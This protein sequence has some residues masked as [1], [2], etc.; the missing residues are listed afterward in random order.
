M[1]NSDD[2]FLRPDATRMRPRP[3]GGRRT[4]VEPPRTQVAQATVGDAGSLPASARALIG[5]GLNPLVRAATPL[6]LL[7]AQIRESLGS[8]DVGGLRRSALEEIH[9]FEATARASR[10]PNEVVLAA[11]YVLCAALDEA[12]LSTPWGNQS[13]WAQHPLLVAVHREAWGGEKFFDMLDRMSQD[14]AQHIDLMELQYLALAFGFAGK[15]Q[16]QERGQD[17]LLE[18]Q[19]ALYQKIREQRGPSEGALSLRWRGLEDRRN[20]LL[21]YLPWWVVAAAAL[22]ILA[23]AFTAYYASLASLAAPVQAELARIG[24]EDFSAPPPAAPPRGPTLKQ[25]LSPDEQR[26]ALSVEE[27]GAK[28]TVTLLAS[29]LFPS[30][31][32]SI[33]AAYVPTLQRVTDALNKVPGRILVVGHTDSQPIKSL[34]F[35]DNFELSRERAVSVVSLLQEGIDNRARLKWTGVGSSEPRYSESDP[36]SRSRNRRVEIIHV[37]GT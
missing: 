29:D 22:P 20:P 7:T 21:R 27:D 28:T 36:A 1:A 24:L 25:L 17:R 8:M 32:A 9:L 35:R 30:G 14:P 16:V 37:S 26:G 4:F 23:I 15:Y 13:E 19:H 2:P 12:V 31:S 3:G 34:R 11:R 6:L 18:I 33:N 10:V 5:I